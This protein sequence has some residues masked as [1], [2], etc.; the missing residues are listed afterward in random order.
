MRT[1]K[2][3]GT[4]LAILAAI[5]WG[6]SGTCGQYLFEQKDISVEWL[7]PVRLLV[8]GLLVL[9]FTFFIQKKAIFGIWKNG[10]DA[11]ELLVFS[12][13]GMLAVQYTYFAA[14]KHSNAATATV[15]QYSGPIIIAIYLAIKKRKLPTGKETLAIVLAVTGTL[16]LVT[17][18]NINTL[19]ISPLALF[20]GLS[21]AVAL[22]IYTLQP[23][24]LLAKYEPSIIIGWGMFCAGLAFCFFRSPWDISGSWDNY[25]LI[26]LIAII[27]LGTLIA[28]TFYLYAVRIIGGQKASLL[29][30]A[31][32][33]AA[34]ILAVYWLATPFSLVDWIGSLCIISTVFL[35]SRSKDEVEMDRTCF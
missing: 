31:E 27:V 25:T 30:S 19:A 12:I 14:I 13:I 15:L 5:F 6:V 2:Y 21:S 23:S 34:T 33:L 22:A 1:T 28:F 20:L 32:P 8:S 17:H 16:L 24:R 10:K 26:N 3:K 35:L 18:G 4:I 7:I 9:A 29:A 11:G